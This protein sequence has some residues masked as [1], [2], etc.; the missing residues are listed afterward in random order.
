MSLRLLTIAVL[1][2]YASTQFLA[3]IR[4]TE[5]PK[6]E[7]FGKS[8]RSLQAKA[9]KPAAAKPKGDKPKDDSYTP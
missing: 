4:L 3:P 6:E 2:A 1:V 8:V 5:N 7:V 9:D